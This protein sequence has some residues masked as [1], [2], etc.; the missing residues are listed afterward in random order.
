MCAYGIRLLGK[1]PAFTTGRLLTLALGMGAATAIFS[2]VDT[3]TAKAIAVSRRGRS[4]R[5][6]GEKPLARIAIECPWLAGLFPGVATKQSR[7]VE[8]MAAIVDSA[9]QPHRRPQRT[10]TRRKSS[11]AVSAAI[12]TARRGTQA[13]PRFPAR[14]TCR[15]T[16]MLSC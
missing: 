16:P 9:D 15:G 5:D 6:L 1:A 14:K 13:G 11:A 2:V 3:G 12:P 8:Q 7:T 10:S 4:A